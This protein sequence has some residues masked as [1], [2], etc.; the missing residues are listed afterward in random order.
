M[1]KRQEQDL[2][3]RLTK[4]FEYVYTPHGLPI[5]NEMQILARR[6]IIQQFER[7]LKRRNA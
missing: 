3:D 4:G 5:C 7:K 6:S 2:H 1:T